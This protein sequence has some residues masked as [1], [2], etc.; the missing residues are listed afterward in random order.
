M[1]VLIRAK[2]EE[3]LQ[4]QKWEELLFSRLSDCPPIVFVCPPFIGE[5]GRIFVA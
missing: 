2:L 5:T 3:S 1:Y 4:S